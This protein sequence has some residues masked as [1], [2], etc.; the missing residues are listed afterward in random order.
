M[1]TKLDSDTRGGVAFA[2]RYALKKPILFVT[3]GEKSGDLEQFRPER[4][5]SRIMGMGDV[6]T[7]IERAEEKIKKSEQDALAKSMAQGKMTLNDFA[8]Q[9]DMMGKLGSL[10]SIM[11]YMPGM[12]SLKVSP[13]MMQKGEVEMKKFQAI[14]SSMTPKERIVTS[15]LDGSRKKRIAAGAGVEVADVNALLTRFE[16]SQQFMKLLKTMGHGK[17]PA[18]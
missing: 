9:M 15:L 10:T 3:T 6:A 13:E 14:I 8:K 17:F 5:A 2:F 12:G 18:R 16:Q 11:K 4:M 1:L 7:L